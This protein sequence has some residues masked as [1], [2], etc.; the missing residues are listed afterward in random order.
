MDRTPGLAEELSEAGDGAEMERLIERNE[1]LD[2]VN[3]LC[4]LCHVLPLLE[5]TFAVRAFHSPVGQP[6]L[7][8]TGPTSAAGARSPYTNTEFAACSDF[9]LA[10]ALDKMGYKKA[11]VHESK[12]KITI[13]PKT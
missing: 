2:A 8:S 4:D 12:T 10:K 13:Q 5:A 1:V 3:P 9:T 7:I 11:I 6:A